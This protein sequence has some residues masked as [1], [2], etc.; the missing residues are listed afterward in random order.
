MRNSGHFA[1]MYG[2]SR[3]SLRLP[4]VEFRRSL[5][6]P[7][8]A[9]VFSVDQQDIKNAQ[10]GGETREGGW[11]DSTE[12][13]NLKEFLLRSS[14]ITLARPSRAV[15]ALIWTRLLSHVRNMSTWHTL[16]NVDKIRC[17]TLT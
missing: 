11:N 6:C 15:L 14:F 9:V 13:E 16:P 4:Q 5:V 3:P 2:L 7:Q 17:Q 10:A 1:F 12:V 8:R